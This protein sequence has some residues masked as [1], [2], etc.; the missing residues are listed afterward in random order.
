MK[1]KL[2]L[3]ATDGWVGTPDGGSHYIWGFVDLTGVP[4]NKLSGFRGKAQLMAPPIVLKVEDEVYLTLTNLGT[5]D[6]KGL[7]EPHTIH[8]HGFPN[9]IPV[10]DGVPEAS[11]AVP[12]T[13][14]LVYYYKPLDPGTYLYHCHHKPA[15]HIQMGMAGPLIV[16]PRDFDPTDI[17]YKT[18]YGHGTGTEFDREYFIF[19]SELDGTIHNLVAK[20]QEPDWTN[21]K[22]TH[23]LINGRSYPDT[24]NTTDRFPGQPWPAAVGANVGERVLLRF[25]NLGFQ[26][27]AIS[28]PGVDFRVVAV[29]AVRLQGLNGED[30]SYFKNIIYIAPGQSMDAIFTAPEAPDLYPATLPLFNR[31]YNK[32]TL[33]GGEMGGMI[34]EVRVYAPGTLPPQAAPS[35]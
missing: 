22:P 15:E 6:R 4:E 12:V 8:L 13:R 25:V 14:D 16:R 32:N 18:A 17:E 33:A 2:R 35:L 23:W 1:V 20:A 27:H 11:M 26:Q 30:L 21:Y 10:Y 31:N 3:G 7:K 19:L 9:Q 28:I 29:D 34:S 24:V 5:P